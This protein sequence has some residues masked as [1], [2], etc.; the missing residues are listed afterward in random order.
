MVRSRIDTRSVTLPVALENISS[1]AV[2][3]LTPDLSQPTQRSS[4][5]FREACNKII[6]ADSVDLVDVSEFSE[7][8]VLS[9][10]VTLW[11]KKQWRRVEID[12]KAELDIPLFLKAACSL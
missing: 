4:L 3:E 7:A 6:H 2:G 8:D 11:G 12:W 9:L 1:T 5:E 10:Q